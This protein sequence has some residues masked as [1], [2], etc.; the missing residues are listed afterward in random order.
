MVVFQI[1]LSILKMSI[2]IMKNHNFFKA[3]LEGRNLCRILL[4]I[5]QLL[6]KKQREVMGW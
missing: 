6:A 1:L 5:A 3:K 4:T 2:K